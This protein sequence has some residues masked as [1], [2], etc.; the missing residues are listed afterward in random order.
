MEGTV[1]GTKVSALAALRTMLNWNVG[2]FSF[3]PGAQPPPEVGGGGNKTLG[4]FL[5]E[6]L[7]LEDEATRAE[8]E[9][10]PSRRRT[11]EFN[12]EPKV[13][14]PALGG[15]PSSPADFAPPS[16][17]TPRPS[18][19]SLLLD[20][21]LAEWEIPAEVGSAPPATPIPHPPRTGH[22]AIPPPAPAPPPPPMPTPVK[23][24]SDQT[25]PAGRA[26]L[27]PPAPRVNIPPPR[28]P[29]PAPSSG[30][31]PHVEKKR[32]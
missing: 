25:P 5:I 3:I 15:P 18:E 27:I 2:R 17:R 29:R 4:A 28:P 9:L 10:P 26:A 23:P 22:Q 13:A 6:A 30:T 24:A 8:L 21:E 14:A 19:L 7:R 16:T 12:R 31:G 11:G 1:G 32:G 20:P